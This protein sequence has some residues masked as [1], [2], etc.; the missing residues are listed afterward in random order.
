MRTPPALPYSG[1]TFILDEPSRFD[2]DVNR[3]LAGPARTFL[4]RDVLPAEFALDSCDI[5]TVDY[6]NP[7]MDGTRAIILSGEKTAEKFHGYCDPP[8]YPT[9][10]FNT[11]TLPTFFIQDSLDYRNLRRDDDGEYEEKLTDRD[12]KEKIPTRA[13]NYR[14]WNL[15]HIKKLLRKSHETSIP[16]L[17]EHAYPRLDEV[18]ACL[19]QTKDS[20]IYLDIETSRRYRCLSCVGFSTA[21]RFPLVYVVPCYLSS[22]DIAYRDFHRFYRALSIALSRN[23]VVIH[24]SMFD[25]SVL[26]GFYHMAYPISVYDTMV[27]HH[28][29]FPEAEKSLAHA[30]SAWTNLGNHKNFNTEV[31]NYEGDRN[32]W[33]YNAQDVFA[34]KIIM[35]RQL[36]YARTIPGL[37][38]S[39]NQ[40]NASILPYLDTTLTGLR[41]DQLSLATTQASLQRKAQLFSRV[42]TI[43]T[44]KTFNPASTKQCADFFHRGLNYEIVSKT[45][46]GAPAMGS[47]QLYQLQLKY[48]NPLIPVILKYREAAKDASSLESELLSLS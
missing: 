9:I 36:D 11:L 15:W 3:L 48:N 5:R 2:K 39:I 30:I 45:P 18:V 21:E 47:K 22:G 25:L 31:Y 14:F 38:D 43:L 23:E 28:R 17:Q 19:H 41:L 6:G 44:G 10:A 8:G 35:D 1:L 29:C 42:A 34:L 32:L 16:A 20:T 33:H 13:K 24:N 40:G 7:I 27:A 4:D 26:C 12:T 46:T 37:L